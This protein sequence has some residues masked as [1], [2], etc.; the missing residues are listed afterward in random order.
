[1]REFEPE[2]AAYIDSKYAIALSNGTLAL[3]PAF[4]A[5]GIG[6]RNGGSD[7]DEVIVMSRTFQ[8]QQLLLLARPVFADVDVNSQ[9]ITDD[10][11]SD[12]R[13]SNAKAIIAVHLAGLQCEMDELMV[14]AD[15]NDLY[16]IED[17]A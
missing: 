14:L 13:T 9:N 5:L 7:T 3:D 11:V 4:V 12:V 8:L 6:S 15:A 10:T 16:V 1:M 17:C 2:F